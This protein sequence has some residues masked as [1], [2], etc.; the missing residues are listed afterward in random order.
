MILQHGPPRHFVLRFVLN[1]ILRKEQLPRSLEIAI[2]IHTHQMS[3]FNAIPNPYSVEDTSITEFSAE[4][5]SSKY[6]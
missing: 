2:V 1:H 3:A 5:C 6:L 4:F